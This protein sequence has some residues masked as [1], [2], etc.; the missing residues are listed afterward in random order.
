M[1][2]QNRQ[3]VLR[4]VLSNA[5]HPEYG[6]VTI[7]FP[8]PVMEYECTLECLAA[9]E[10]GARLKR[11]CRVDELES[12]FPILKR[13]EGVRANLD[14]MD[15]LARRLDS[16]DKYEAAQFQAM[17]VRL[18]TFDMTDFINLTFCCQQAT[19]ITNFSDLEDIGKAHILTING[20]CLYADEQEQVDGRAEALKLIL[21]E[22]GTVT[23]MRWSMTTV[24]SWNS[25]T[26]RAAP[27]RTILTGSSSYSWRRPRRRAEHS[28]DPAGQPSQAGTAPVPHRYTGQPPGTLQGS[29]QHPAR[30]GDQQHSIGTSV[31]Q[32]PQ[33]AVPGGGADCTG[34]SENPGTT[35][36]RQGPPSQGL[37]I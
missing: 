2:T 10:L 26:R 35:A 15:Y 7:P 32:W 27:S 11:D 6:Q 34:G 14:E 1:T 23:P 13:L 37:S 29:G 24:W 22:H 25:S 3:P 16:F 12:G 33:P 18:G 9:M 8:I 5:A 21:N 30:R 31:H 19:V 20:G 28:A 17:A 4:C 36:G